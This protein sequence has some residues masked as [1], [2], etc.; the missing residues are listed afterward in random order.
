MGI[1]CMT[2]FKEVDKGLRKKTILAYTN[3]P[4]KLLGYIDTSLTYLNACRL[5]LS[6]IKTRLEMGHINKQEFRSQTLKVLK[7]VM[8][9]VMDIKDYTSVEA[10][11]NKFKELPQGTG[12]ENV[13]SKGITPAFIE[14]S[15]TEIFEGIKEIIDIKE[16][17][18]FL[19]LPEKN[20]EN[21]ETDTIYN[22]DL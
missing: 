10:F 17:K 5:Q 9:E 11:Q 13:N 12:Q 14:S 2:N 3:D 6:I 18:D 21:I 16:F 15:L 20:N 7:K 4:D 8:A 1:I 22:S 19:Y